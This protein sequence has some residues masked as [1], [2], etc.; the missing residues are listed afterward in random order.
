M[1]TALLA[2]RFTDMVISE[3]SAERALEERVLGDVAAERG[4]APTDLALDLA[5]ATDLE[6]RFR[7]AVLNTDETI[8]A[9][10]LTHPATMIGLSDAGAHASQ[11]C[12]ACAPT[13]LLG[14]WVRDMNVLTMEDAVRRLSSAR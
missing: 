13:E 2:G 9:E 12:D 5:L 6:T 4:V 14:K 7:L 8:T 11:L 10:L 3:C 1:D